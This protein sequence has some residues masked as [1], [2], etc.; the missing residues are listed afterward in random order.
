[1]FDFREWADNLEGVF[2]PTARRNLVETSDDYIL[3]SELKSQLRTQFEHLMVPDLG[4]KEVPA[5]PDVATFNV[6]RP[7]GSVCSGNDKA[8][9]VEID[10]RVKNTLTIALCLDCL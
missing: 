1:M 4:D 2:S 5:V 6:V 9:S 7:S 10:D 8:M 3:L